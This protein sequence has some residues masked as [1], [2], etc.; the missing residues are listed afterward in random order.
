[1]QSDSYSPTDSS[2]SENTSNRHQ[3]LCFLFHST[4]LCTST[5]FCFLL[6]DRYF[7]STFGHYL[8]HES[9]SYSP[10]AH[11]TI[12]NTSNHH[13]LLCYLVHSTSLCTSTSFSYLL[14]DRY[15]R[16]TFGR[17]MYHAVRFIFSDRPF[18]LRKHIKPSPTT[19]LLA[20]FYFT[21]HFTSFSYL[22]TDR[23]FRSTFGRSMYHESDSYSPTANS[24]IENTSNRHPLLC[25]LVHSTSSCTS[26]SFSYLPTDRYFRSIFDHSRYHAVRLI[27]SDRPFN[28]RKHIKPSPITVLL[29][30]F[31]LTMHF[32]HIQL[33]SD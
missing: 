32:Y 31:Y 13:Q 9:D 33:S 12:E 19:V 24:T 28:L 4:S 2:T 21:M 17:S 27:F 23:Y 14:I 3:L 26:T 18:N 5:S 10:T 7:R 1:M 29:A 11:S 8:Y 25:Y 20:P 6:T 16:S 22:P 15:F 30:P